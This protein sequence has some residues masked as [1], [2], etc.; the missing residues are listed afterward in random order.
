[1][2]RKIDLKHDQVDLRYANWLKQ[3]IDLISPKNLYLIAGRGMGK[4]SDVLAER[5]M[6]IVY[7][8]PG[9]SFAFVGDTYI[10]LQKNVDRKSVV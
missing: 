5:S 10:N 4:T 1:M 3:T 8:M 2:N 9:G 7:D 6:D